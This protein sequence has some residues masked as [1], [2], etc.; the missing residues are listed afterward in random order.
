[1]RVFFLSLFSKNNSPDAVL[2]RSIAK[3]I[4]HT[5][6]NLELYKSALTHG[7]TIR[8]ASV[9]NTSERLEFLGDAVI[10]MITSEYLYKKFPDQREGFLTQ[11][12]SRI[13]SRQNLAELAQRLTLQPLLLTYNVR[14]SKNILGN[15][16]EALIGAMYLDIGYRQTAD[17][18]IDAVKK[19]LDVDGLP[20]ENVNCKGQLLEMAQHRKWN[21]TFESKDERKNPQTPMFHCVVRLEGNIIGSGVGRTKKEAQQSAAHKAIVELGKTKPVEQPSDDDEEHENE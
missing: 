18:F 7:S 12:R 17:F 4:G 21:I 15:A 14:I 1:M 20:A 10:E 5:P 11:Q 16:F 2:K 9:L 13:V 19:V 8:T 3:R 6:R